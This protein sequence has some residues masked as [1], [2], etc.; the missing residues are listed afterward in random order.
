MNSEKENILKKLKNNGCRITRQRKII[1]D[2]I[3]QNRC[4]SCKEIYVQA[5]KID[6][7]IGRATVYRMVKELEEIGALS[8]EIVYK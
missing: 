2:I 3:L 6:Q 4:S 8:R 1:L 7:N 5:T